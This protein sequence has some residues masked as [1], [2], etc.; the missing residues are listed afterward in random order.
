[1]G[2]LSEE[3]E[4]PMSFRIGIHLGE[5]VLIET[6]AEDVA[7]GAK[8]LEVEGLAKP[9]AARL[10]S[11][12]RGGQTLLSQGAF[13]LARQA[14]VG[15]LE[16]ADL[17]WVAHGQYKLKGVAE[18][19]PVFE[20]GRRG[21]AP[22]EA[23]GDTEKVRRLVSDATVTGWRPSV[24]QEIPLRPRWVLEEK[25]GEGGFGEVWLAR[26]LKTGERRAFKFCFKKAAVRAL[27]REITLFRLLKETLGGAR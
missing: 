1:M 22:L 9:T 25:L 21:V 3:I 7:R 13:N 12:A 2:E 15:R 5:V 18:P 19:M 26:Y 10:M 20:A 17:E 27:Q 14:A 4:I 11:L 16:I 8:P 6:P 24:G 23:P